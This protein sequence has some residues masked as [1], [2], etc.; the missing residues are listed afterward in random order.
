[1]GHPASPPAGHAGQGRG[2]GVPAAPALRAGLEGAG[3][4]G[5]ITGAAANRAGEGL[6]GPGA[7]AVGA[8]AI[9]C[10]YLHRPSPTADAAGGEPG[11]DPK[12]VFPLSGTERTG[13]FHHFPSKRSGCTV[14]SVSGCTFVIGLYHRKLKDFTL[15]FFP[16]A[17]FFLWPLA[18][19]DAGRPLLWPSLTRP[20]GP[21]RR[22]L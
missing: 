2:G 20:G 21:V 19:Y 3:D 22:L 11:H 1:L 17:P 8:P 5:H 9:R 4:H 18:R 15:S 16:G 12:G 7:P 10:G 13:Y 6:D 14:F